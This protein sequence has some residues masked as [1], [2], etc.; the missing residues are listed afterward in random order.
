MKDNLGTVYPSRTQ[1]IVTVGALMLT[2]AF[3]AWLTV[4]FVR[5]ARAESEHWK[6]TADI[7]SKDG[8]HV[9]LVYGNPQ[10]GPVYFDTEAACKT[11]ITDK[12]STFN[13]TAWKTVQEAAKKMKATVATPTCVMDLDLP[14]KGSI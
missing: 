14:K 10:T 1:R 12:K 8:E 2:V 9:K 3:L 4:M 5:P 6:I 13:T 7:V 11:E